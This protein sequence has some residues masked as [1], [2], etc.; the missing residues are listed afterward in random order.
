MTTSSE[1]YRQHGPYHWWWYKNKP[2]YTYYVDKV[3]AWIK[4]SNVLDVGAGDGLIVHIL[5]IKGID[6]VPHAVELAQRRGANVILGDAH[7]LP[8]K[9]EEF[10]SVFMGNTLEHLENPNEAIK[11]TRRI[12]RKYLYLVVAVKEGTF[13]ITPD[14][15]KE[16]VE[17]EGFVLNEI[18][19][20]NKAIWGKF[21]KI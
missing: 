20:E 21:K 16:M 18:S 4:E 12:L 5:G 3:K 10:E 14:E 17:N 6:N 1:K 13:I 11:E 7:N 9:D 19:I 8:F 2:T 15:L